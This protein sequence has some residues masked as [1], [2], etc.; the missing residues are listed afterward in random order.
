MKKKKPNKLFEDHDPEEDQRD[1]R[2]YFLNEFL[3]E[4]AVR[5]EGEEAA[6]EAIFDRLTKL[7]RVVSGIKRRR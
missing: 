3:P 4:G 1:L 2:E 7:A 5:T 6:R